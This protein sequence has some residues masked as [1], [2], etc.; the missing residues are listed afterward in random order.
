[1]SHRSSVFWCSKLHTLSNISL[2]ASISMLPISA[3]QSTDPI[4][5]TTLSLTDITPK[6][7]HAVFAVCHPSAVEKYEQSGKARDLYLSG[8][9]GFV[10]V[11]KVDVNKEILSLLSPCAG[12]LPSQHLLVGDNITWVE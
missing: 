9:A 6:F 10:A 5:L 12:S 7:Q 8:V 2:T 4:Q 11:E 1:M 3:K